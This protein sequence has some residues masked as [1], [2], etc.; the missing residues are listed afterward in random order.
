MG[1]FKVTIN[2]IS[3]LLMQLLQK[4]FIVSMFSVALLLLYFVSYDCFLTSKVYK[5]DVRSDCV[6]IALDCP[7]AIMP[8]IVPLMGH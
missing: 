6:S 1:P 2:C 5:S 8:V 3:V 7:G 4:G